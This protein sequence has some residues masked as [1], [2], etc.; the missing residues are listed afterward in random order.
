MPYYLLV[1]GSPDEIPQEFIYGL[2]AHYAV[3]RIHFNTLDEYSCYAHSVVEAEIGGVLGSR[4]VTLFAPRNRDDLATRAVCESLAR[5]LTQLLRDSSPSWKIESLLGEDATKNNLA[6]LLERNTSALLFTASQTVTFR[7]DDARQL[8]QQG[9]IICQEWLG[10]DA[11]PLTPSEYFSAED[12]SSTA[13]V[14][15]LISI[16]VGS[17][18]AGTSGRGG[19][20][21]TGIPHPR[22][23]FI[24][25][26]VQRLLAHPNG[27]ALAVIGQFESSG[28]FESDMN[29]E[30]KV[31][32]ST[33]RL[34]MDGYPVGAAMEFLNQRYVEMSARI[35]FILEESVASFPLDRE[36]DLRQLIAFQGARMYALLGDPGVRLPFDSAMRRRV[37]RG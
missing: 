22:R 35:Y 36:K 18:T 33:L 10:P 6:N 8:S 20:G 5:P 3:G 37:L 28:V 30:V 4:K 21:P 24:S 16:H 11:G 15:G 2:S 9:A 34:L 12:V 25:E 1:I 27:G 19:F 31:L 14:H 32:E 7:E 26:L 13:R 23:A 29:I 17:Y